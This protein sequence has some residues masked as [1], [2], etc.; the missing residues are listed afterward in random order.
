M[1]SDQTE[2][3][4]TPGR[5]VTVTVNGAR[6]TAWCADRTLLA[7]F[8]RDQLRLPGTHVGCMNGDCGACTVVVDGEIVKS[9]LV[10]AVA[11]DGATLTTVEGL[12]TP[13]QL[14]PLQQAF[15]EADAFQC[16]FCLP[17]QLLAARDLL[18]TEPQPSEGQIRSAIAGNL[19]RCTGYQ[20]IVEAV[21]AAAA[22]Q[23]TEGTRGA[24]SFP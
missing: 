2:E 23:A 20:P 7:D 4:I 22:A 16:G 24:P 6:R 10:L 14:H 1:M 17:G 18:E 9:C 15:W 13:D 5:N 12:G 21:Q 11:V 3:A 19:C 8:V